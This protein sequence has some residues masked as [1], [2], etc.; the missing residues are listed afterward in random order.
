M[1]PSTGSTSAAI[2]LGRDELG[3]VGLGAQRVD[4][5]ALE[6]LGVV[7]RRAVGIARD[8]AQLGHLG[9]A[10]TGDLGEAAARVEGAAR[11]PA[12]QRRRRPGDRQ[13]R[14]VAGVVEA[15][16]A[17]Q[18]A[19]GVRV[20]RLVEDLLGGAHL[21]L[22]AGVHHHHLVGQARPPRRGRG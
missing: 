9:V 2:D 22:A 18:Q 20:A 19:E 6:R 21:H 1:R 8:E 15:R 17:R 16:E 14:L 7:A 11:R 4:G 10:E 12:D 3:L 13:E 5:D